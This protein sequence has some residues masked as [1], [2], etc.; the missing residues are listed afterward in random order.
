[1]SKTKYEIDSVDRYYYF[2]GRNNKEYKEVTYWYDP[3]TLERKETVRTVH[4][5]DG[6]EYSLPEWAKSI[7]TRNRSLESN[8][9]Y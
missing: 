1:M 6:N 4:C 5:Y 7:T 3:I 2:C 9:I 8:H